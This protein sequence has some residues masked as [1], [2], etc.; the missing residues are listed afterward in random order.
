MDQELFASVD[1]YLTDHL[2]PNDP[3]LNEALKANKDAGLPTIDVS[4]TQGKLLYLLA[5]M[6]SAKRI[7]E[8]GT[9][10][11]YSTIWLARALPAEGKLITLELD[12]KHAKV[13]AT[14]IHRAGLTHLVEQ[15]VGPALDSLATLH[16]EK[17]APF[18]LIFLDADKPN[19]PNYL[20]WAIRLSHP[21]TVIIGDN[22]IRDGDIIHP[23]NTDPSVQGT[24]RFLEKLGAHPQ[25]E[26]TAIQ[27][28]GSKGYDGFAIAIVKTTQP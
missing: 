12:P 6:A 10:G 18:D 11:G 2:I 1:H 20:D 7:L 14:N 16:A 24:R 21:G 3:P 23:D 27:T 5:R 13:A 8:V 15:R 17:P 9:L 22:V 26:A 25:L 19:N 28:V 4:P